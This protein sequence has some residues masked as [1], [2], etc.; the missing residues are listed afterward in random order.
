[1]KKIY[2]SQENAFNKFLEGFMEAF[3]ENGI[4]E[5]I[6]TMIDGPL[7]GRWDLRT[8][9]HETHMFA[10]DVKYKGAPNWEKFNKEGRAE[11][12][13]ADEDSFYQS[14]FDSNVYD[15]FGQWTTEFSTRL[16]INLM[17]GGRSG[18]WWG[19]SSEKLCQDEDI[20][21]VKIDKLREYYDAHSAELFN[22]ADEEDED[23]EFYAGQ[24]F[25]CDCST[26]ELAEYFKLSDEFVELC[27][28]FSSDVDSTSDYWDSDEF[29]D[30]E[31]NAYADMRE[32]KKP[33]QKRVREMDENLLI[34]NALCDNAIR[35]MERMFNMSDGES[36]ILNDWENALF[37][38]REPNG[39]T[40]KGRLIQWLGQEG[41]DGDAL[42][43]DVLCS[44]CKNDP[45]LKSKAKNWKVV[46]SDPEA[47]VIEVSWKSDFNESF[48]GIYEA[49]VCAGA[50]S[51]GGKSA[52][53]NFAPENALGIEDIAPKQQESRKCMP[54][55]VRESRALPGGM[56]DSKEK[57]DYEND[58]LKHQEAQD[59][60]KDKKDDENL[61]AFLFDKECGENGNHEKDGTLKGKK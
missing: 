53:V 19:F 57:T 27:N 32:S 6:L 7:N 1:M 26:E 39:A 56:L 28:E 3:Q 16:G 36:D 54:R 58:L 37:F 15:F 55:S 40:I 12:I 34:V 2:E 59:K 20:I 46:R 41:L 33:T 29:N 22:A 8:W 52:I 50:A 61:N 38:S 43:Y 10:L 44:C 21:Q 42:W 45:E 31:F 49:C 30:E 18:G 13:G 23:E 24:D 51:G 35:Q 9:Y 17:S 4:D 60:A 48:K 11:A 47:G 25:Y 5:E 14:H